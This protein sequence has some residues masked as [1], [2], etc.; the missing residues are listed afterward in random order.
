[1]TYHTRYVSRL[2]SKQALMTAPQVS[3]PPW[4]AAELA[5]RV[6]LVAAIEAGTVVL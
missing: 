6:A 4:N 1:M 3:C 2:A 5:R